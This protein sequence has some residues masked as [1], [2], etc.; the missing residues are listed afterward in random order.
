MTRSILVGLAILTLSTSAALA[1]HRTHHS[2]AMNAYAA[3][4]YGAYW[5]RISQE[6]LRARAARR[7][8]RDSALDRRANVPAVLVSLCASEGPARPSPTLLCSQERVMGRGRERFKP[9]LPNSV[10]LFAG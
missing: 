6:G 2:H 8:V 10:V 4:P 7:R 1:A 9:A 5:L 3:M